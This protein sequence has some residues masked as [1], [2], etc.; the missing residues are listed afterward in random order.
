[1]NEQQQ[2]TLA[3]GLKALAG[4]TRDAAASRRVGDAVLAEARRA[5]ASGATPRLAITSSRRWL[6]LAAALLLAVAGAL[7]G[8]GTVAPGARGSVIHPQGFMTLPSAYGMPEIESASIIR[9][10]VPLSALPA[11]GLSIAPD[12]VTDS[13]EAELLVAQDGQPRA[14]RLVDDPLDTRSRP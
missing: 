5:A 7:W 8:A 6:P 13:I 1:M 12:A 2:R 10:Q 11:Y 3:A 14:I 9:I 4:T